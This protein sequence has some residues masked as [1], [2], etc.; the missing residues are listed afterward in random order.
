MDTINI[1][2]ADT[3]L[4]S[5]VEKAANGETFI[6]AKAGKPMAKVVPLDPPVN[7]NKKIQRIGFMEGHGVIPDDIKA[8]AKDEIDEMFG[9]KE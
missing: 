3:D 8:F 5:L 1:E 7:E 4:S 9:L 2:D 6:I